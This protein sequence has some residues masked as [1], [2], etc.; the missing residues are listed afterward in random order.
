MYVCMAR[1]GV[2]HLWKGWHF[3]IFLNCW[4]A[5]RIR[6]NFQSL[7]HGGRMTHI[8]D[9]KL[10]IISSDNGLSLGRRQA[11]IWTS[12]GYIVNWTPRKNLSEILIKS[13]TFSF[14]KI[15]LE[16]SSGKWRP[17]CLGLN[18]LMIKRNFVKIMFTLLYA[19]CLLASTATIMFRC[20]VY[21]RIILI[22][23]TQTDPLSRIIVI[24]SVSRSCKTGYR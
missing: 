19:L 7:T 13:H 1:S 4:T 21:T 2:V 20:C 14:K 9:S 18:V 10:T 24:P 16:M 6:K 3:I 8:C 12:D 17:L 23:K 22:F 15:Q 11:I 5:A